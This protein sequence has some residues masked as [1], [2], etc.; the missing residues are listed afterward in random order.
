MIP[1]SPR[2]ALVFTI[3]SSALYFGPDLLMPRAWSASADYDFYYACY[4]SALVVV[5]FWFSPAICR[6]MVV[7][8][9]DS[10][11]IIG[12][13]G[14]SICNL[15]L[16]IFDHP[17]PFV[18][19]A[20]LLPA[21]CEIFLSKGFTDRLT[22]PGRRFLLARATTHG[23]WIQ[24]LGAFVP[25]LLFAWFFPGI[26]DSLK[27]W[28]DMAAFL[29]LWLLLHWG[30]EL[31]VDR[32]AARLCGAGAIDGLRDLLAVTNPH[33]SR[34]TTQPPPGWRVRAVRG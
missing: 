8:K 18:L 2:R 14:E 20:G 3:V 22:L 27:A 4:Q 33:N 19:T 9:L 31:S 17:V 15:P 12:R 25:A 7:R 28:L 23:S 6:S 16:T 32:A 26:P 21:Q 11:T 10:E 1:S 34:L 13:A 30:L 29:G 24:R 5:A